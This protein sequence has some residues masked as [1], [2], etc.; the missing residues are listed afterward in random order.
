MQ[1]VLSL[2]SGALMIG[3]VYGLSFIPTATLSRTDEE[4]GLGLT[5]DDGATPDINTA[6]VPPQRRRDGDAA[7]DSDRA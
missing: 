6:D 1:A 2:V 5:D 4:I 7:Q 3:L